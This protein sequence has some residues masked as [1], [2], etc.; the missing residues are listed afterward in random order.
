MTSRRGRRFGAFMGGKDKREYFEGWYL[1]HQKGNKT[2]SFIPSYH[3][4]KDGR[5]S[6]L[7][8]VITEENAWEFRFLPSQYYGDR[9]RFYCQIGENV[10]CEKGIRVNLK[11]EAAE[12]QGVLRYGSLTPPSRDIMGPL[13]YFTMECN[14]GILSLSH[15]IHGSLMINGER[16]NFNGGCG[17]IEKDWGT[18]FPEGYVWTQCSVFDKGHMA[19]T[20]AVAKVPVGRWKFSG[21]IAI[22]YYGGRQY[23]LASYLG[24]RIFRWNSGEF[25]IC[26]GRDLLWVQYPWKGGQ[27]L[28]SPV[29][30]RMSGKIQEALSCEIRYRFWRKGQLLLD[31]T[32]E[33]GSLEVVNPSC[34]SSIPT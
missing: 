26:Q 10:F 18:S 20:A 6:I 22:V 15:K 25:M 4:E 21:C 32:A 14:H 7:I 33:N 5:I 29:K 27:S 13:S 24:A 30:G 3:V 19:F 1:K 16:Y 8:Q 31:V 23:R 9:K 17:Y 28:R 34:F 12:I 11:S 2:L